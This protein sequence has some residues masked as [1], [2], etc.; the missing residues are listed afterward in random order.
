MK[1]V[2]SY[3]KTFE[4]LCGQYLSFGMTYEEYWNGDPEIAKYYRDKHKCERKLRNQELWL[5]GAYIYEALLD[6]Y[7]VLNPLSNEKQPIPYRSEPLPLSDEEYQK[8]KEDKK[9]KD[10]ENAKRKMMEIMERVNKRF[11][12]DTTR[13][14]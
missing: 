9:A 4:D 7:P 10:K 8:Q 13:R 14:S 3:K 2:L 1:T 12:D 6:V 11:T 5:Q